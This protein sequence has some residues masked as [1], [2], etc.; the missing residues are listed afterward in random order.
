MSTK[1]EVD[2]TSLTKTFNMKS[3]KRTDGPKNNVPKLKKEELS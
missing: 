2:W 3:D 1:F